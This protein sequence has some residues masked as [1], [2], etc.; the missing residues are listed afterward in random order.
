VASLKDIKRKVGAVQKTKQI[1]RAMNMVAASKFKSS[2]VRMENFRPYAG[3][4]MDVLNSLALRVD[5]ILIRFWLS[6]ILK[7]SGNLHDF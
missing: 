3:K 5:T 7:N 6:A 4:F 2:Q 1:T